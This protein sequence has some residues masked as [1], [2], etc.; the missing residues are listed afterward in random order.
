VVGASV[1]GEGLSMIRLS[2]RGGR[3]FMEG[4]YKYRRGQEDMTYEYRNRGYGVGNGNRQK[5][6]I[7]TM[8]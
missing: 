1:Q 6:F 3:A 7:S 2:L 8:M 4:R 5:T